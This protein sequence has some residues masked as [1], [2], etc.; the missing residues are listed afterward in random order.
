MAGCE[1]LSRE[2]RVLRVLHNGKPVTARVSPKANVWRRRETGTLDMLKKG[3][4]L[5]I[6]FDP[7]KDGGEQAD[8]SCAN[9]V[10]FYGHILAT[11]LFSVR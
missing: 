7:T 3:D 11:R 9:L 2:G 6:R 8:Y 4:I 1:L 5:D 10:K